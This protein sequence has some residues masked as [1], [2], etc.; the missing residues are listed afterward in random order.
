MAREVEPT[1]TYRGVAKDAGHGLV[2]LVKEAAAVDEAL[3]LLGGLDGYGL[4]DLELELTDSGVGRECMEDERLR[5]AGC[6]GFD[7]DSEG[8]RGVGRGGI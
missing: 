2:A 6:G 8:G 4:A 1:Q 5:D 3:G 7:L